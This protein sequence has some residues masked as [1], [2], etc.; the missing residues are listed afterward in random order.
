M[1]LTRLERLL[2]CVSVTLTILLVAVACGPSSQPASAFPP[3]QEGFNPVLVAE[4]AVYERGLRTDVM[5][6][7][8]VNGKVPCVA[9]VHYGPYAG[10]VGLDC[11]FGRGD[12]LEGLR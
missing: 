2:I 10:G 11:D 3:L 4:T 5:R 9:L 8:I 1:K 6:I 7:Y 12:V